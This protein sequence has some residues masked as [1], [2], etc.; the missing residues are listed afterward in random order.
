MCSCSTPPHPVTPSHRLSVCMH[1]CASPSLSSLIFCD[2]PTPRPTVC[3]CVCM[4]VPR[5]LPAAFI[6]THWAHSD[7]YANRHQRKHYKTKTDKNCVWLVVIEKMDSDNWWKIYLDTVYQNEED[8]QEYMRAFNV[9][10]RTHI[11]PRVPTML[12]RAATHV[13]KGTHYVTKDGGFSWSNRLNENF[14]QNR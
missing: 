13:I 7:Q 2:T 6:T 9:T 11:L 10:K 14:L 4:C 3:L 12:P 8:L 5:P 1:V